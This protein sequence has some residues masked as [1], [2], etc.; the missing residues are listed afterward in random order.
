MVV[1]NNDTL[2]EIDPRLPE[3]DLK[4][5][6]ASKATALGDVKRVEALLQQARNNE[7]RANAL[8][9]ENED[10]ISL[11]ELDQFKFGTMSLEAQLEI[12]EASVDQASASLDNAQTNV[13]YATIKYTAPVDENGE[14]VDGIIIDRKIENGMTLQSGF[15]TPE[16][17]VI[18]LYMPEKMHVHAS[19]DEADIGLIKKAKE[20]ERLVHF[21]VDAYPDDLFEG[22][23]FEV[24]P[25]PTETQNVVTYPVIVE[26]TKPNTD[27]KLLP[28]MTASIS[29]RVEE[30]FD[31]VK[32][33]NSALRFYPQKKH[34]RKEDHELL[35]GSDWENKKDDDEPDVMLSAEEKAEARKARNK[36][37]VWVAEGTKLKAVAVVTGLSDS[38]FT[39]LVS[40]DVT[41]DT[42]LV[43]GIKTEK[44]LGF[45]MGQRHSGRET[46]GRSE[47]PRGKRGAS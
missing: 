46:H 10:Y 30:R 35:E 11:T 33:P 2:A 6:L 5:A 12:S 4:R 13:D 7:A 38:K 23:I 34:V 1:K 27:L 9:E 25:S 47:S 20:Q 8:R 44:R 36:R 16:L 42:K 39:E 45:L 18:A 21:T 41:V 28:G 32:I 37:H 14:F 15:Q 26:T 3:A 29:F 24:R 22:K 31:I 19:V 17:F 40:G 43:T